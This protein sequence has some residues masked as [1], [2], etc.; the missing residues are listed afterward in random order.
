MIAQRLK[1]GGRIDRTKI[2]GFTWYGKK[3]FGFHGDS[4]A[5]ALMVNNIKIIGRSF[6]FIVI[7]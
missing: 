3:Y 5:S 2:L 4:L 7:S 1:K 6:A